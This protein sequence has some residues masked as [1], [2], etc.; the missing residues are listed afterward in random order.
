METPHSIIITGST[1]GFGRLTA[2][3]LA[4]RGHTVFAGV[5]ESTGRNAAAAGELRALAA[6]AGLALHV[7]DLDVTDDASVERAVRRVVE[8]AGRLD[9][10]VN[11]AGTF[12]AGPLEAVTPEQARQQFDTNVFGAL[13][14]NRA[15]LP[16]MRTQGGGLLVQVSS[17][18]GRLALPFLGLYSASKFAVEGLTEAYRQELAP[19]GIEVVLIEPGTYPTGLGAK[20]AMAA[21]A[22]R[23]A[24][25]GPTVQAF[26]RQ[27][28]AAAE[29]ADPQ[30][31]ADAIA[32]VIAAPAGTRVFRMVVAPAG[33]GD[34]PAALNAAAERAAAALRGG[35]G[36]TTVA[37]RFAGTT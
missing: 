25:Y 35:L 19:F 26:L 27:F 3:T 33:Q 30:A 20:R 15:A 1:S 36:L 21:D 18:L 24:P 8:T 10:V 2:E 17:V 12:A 9:V 13:R 29:G 16:Q 34:G 28:A 32:R 23:Y 31:V 22:A 37:A 7:V 11:N 4:R 5:R 6:G 14:M